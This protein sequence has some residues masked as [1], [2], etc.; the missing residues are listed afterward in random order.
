MTQSQEIKPK[1]FFNKKIQTF[2]DIVEEREKLIEKENYRRNKFLELTNLGYQYLSEFE[3]TIKYP[4]GEMRT[5]YAMI[6][7]SIEDPFAPLMGIKLILVS[8][9]Q[10]ILWPATIP[11]AILYDWIIEPVSNYFNQE[12]KQEYEKQQHEIKSQRYK[13]SGFLGL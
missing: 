7:Y 5:G 9:A 2:A 6:F 4:I 10:I 3:A 12:K 11:K 1:P 13:N 8:I